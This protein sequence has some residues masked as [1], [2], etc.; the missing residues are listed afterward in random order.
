MDYD[1]EK[2]WKT[3]AYTVINIESGAKNTIFFKKIDKIII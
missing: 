3:L 2:L 1:F